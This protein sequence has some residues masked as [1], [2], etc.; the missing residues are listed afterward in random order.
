MHVVVTGFGPFGA[1][2]KNPSWDVARGLADAFGRRG[3]RAFAV[4]WETTF[5]RAASGPAALLAEAPGAFLV[6]CGVA[7]TRARISLERRAQNVR[8][9]SHTE[10]RSAEP[11]L[12]GGPPERRTCLD[13]DA[14]V[15]AMPGAEA[16]EDAGDFVCNAAYYASLGVTLG[17]SLFVHVPAAVDPLAAAEAFVDAWVR[18]VPSTP[19]PPSI[20]R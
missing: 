6:H 15:A 13:V 2:R 14:L 4:E 19:C 20:P 10:T 18:V 11:L 1:I 8:G 16:S 5:A 9:A 12:P 17:R 7:V 3:L